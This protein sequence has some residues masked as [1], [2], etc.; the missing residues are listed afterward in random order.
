M[1]A[2][3]VIEVREK[4]RGIQRF[5]DI[6]EVTSGRLTPEWVDVDKENLKGTVSQLPKREQI[7]VPV[8]EM[9]IVEL[10]SK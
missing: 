4:S 10:Y 1:K 6:S 7:D 3:D 9:Y 2:G 5:K 8:D